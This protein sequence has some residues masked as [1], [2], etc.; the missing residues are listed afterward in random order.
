VC[1]GSGGNSRAPLANGEQTE[2]VWEETNPNEQPG[3][4]VSARTRSALHQSLHTVA[5]A[6]ACFRVGLSA[7]SRAVHTQ[8]NKH[9]STLQSAARP[10]QQ[11]TAGER[12]RDRERGPQRGSALPTRRF[13]LIAAG[14]A[15]KASNG[16]QAAAAHVARTVGTVTVG[17]RG[18]TSVRSSPLCRCAF[19]PVCSLPTCGPEQPLVGARS[20]APV[21]AAIHRADRPTPGAGNPADCTRNRRGRKR[22][23]PSKGQGTAASP[24]GTK[25]NSNRWKVR[26]SPCG[27]WSLVAGVSLAAEV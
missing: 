24:R 8:N 16:M 27:T 14:W 21:H 22:R 11:W 9:A 12:A 20:A 18:A 23:S 10:Q 7:A 5:E 6:A 15:K 26:R 19:L 13:G 1:D 4:T 3:T 25:A 2:T 17:R